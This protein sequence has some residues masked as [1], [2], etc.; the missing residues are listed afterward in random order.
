MALSS[1]GSSVAFASPAIGGGSLE[2]HLRT[3][4][5]FLAQGTGRKGEPVLSKTLE[6]LVGPSYERIKVKPFEALSAGNA[7]PR[8]CQRERLPDTPASR[9]SNSTRGLSG[10]WPRT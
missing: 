7:R 1:A 3:R 2:A 8:T 6:L 4:N 5:A 10:E 9:P